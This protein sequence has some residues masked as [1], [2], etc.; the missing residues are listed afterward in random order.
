[1]QAVF[2]R[3]AVLAKVSIV[4]LI[5]TGLLLSRRAPQWQG[6]FSTGNTYSAVLAAKHG[7]VILMVGIA[8]ARAS[9]LS[10]NK[11]LSP[12]RNRL[13]AALLLAN[14]VLGVAVLALSAYGAVIDSACIVPR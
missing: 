1:M 2:R 8:A 5:V 12:G 6:L 7:L 13:L 10:A 11:P 9:L 3:L 14:I 4:G